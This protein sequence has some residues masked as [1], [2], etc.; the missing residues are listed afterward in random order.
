MRLERLLREKW[1]LY[2]EKK[3]AN[4]IFLVAFGLDVGALVINN[5]IAGMR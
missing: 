2:E 1:P 5:Q 4:V 3:N